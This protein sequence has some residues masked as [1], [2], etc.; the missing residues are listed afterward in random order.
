MW[1]FNVRQEDK[2]FTT[3]QSSKYYLLH[4]TTQ[5]MEQSTT[6]C[7]PIIQIYLECIKMTKNL[8]ESAI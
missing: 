8:S 6:I 1:A 3:A 5:Y 7:D 4:T 2:R